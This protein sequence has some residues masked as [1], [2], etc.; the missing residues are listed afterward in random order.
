[1]VHRK[2]GLLL[3]IA[4]VL[5]S[6]GFS[7]S[8]EAVGEVMAQYFKAIEA[9]DYPSAADFYA[10]AFFKN[11]SRDAW[12]AQLQ[13]YR[14]H[15]GDLESFEAVN[16]KVKKNVGAHAGTFVQ[17]VYKTRYSR[18]PAMER[19]ILKKADQGFRINAHRLHAD[20][21]PKGK[22]QFI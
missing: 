4:L 13:T 20:A 10:P 5:S 17:V 3:T 12:E 9:Q 14:R 22:T 1:M 18:H 11:T 8:K 21:L 15:L 2:I 6:C 16:W 19:F 7:A